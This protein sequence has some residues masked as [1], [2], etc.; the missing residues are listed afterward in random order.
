MRSL[1]ISKN[2]IMLFNSS[3][4]TNKDSILVTIISKPLAIVGALNTSLKSRNIFATPTISVSMT[5]GIISLIIIS[6]AFLNNNNM[7]N[8]KRINVKGLLRRKDLTKI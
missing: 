4:T 5:R 3:M 6:T 2:S 1:C 7:G 8:F